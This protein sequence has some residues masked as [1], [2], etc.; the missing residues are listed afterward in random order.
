MIEFAASFLFGVLASFTP[1]MV[2]LYP[3]LFYRLSREK[4]VLKTIMLVSLGFLVVFSIFALFLSQI[5]FEKIRFGF[6]LVLVALGIAGLLKIIPHLSTKLNT[7]NPFLFG[8]TMA[9]VFST[10]PCSLPFLTTIISGSVAINAN[11]LINILVFSLGLLT[12]IILFSFL[13]NMAISHILMKY[14]NKL[15]ALEK[16]LN[17][18]IA[19]TGAYLV[20][21]IHELSTY[22]LWISSA[23]I[24]I[25]I[26][27]I[28][29]F[30]FPD[31]KKEKFVI[32]L[33]LSLILI[34]GAFIYHCQG[35]VEPSGEANAV[36]SY[37][38][39]CDYC[40]KCSYLFLSATI[41]GITAIYLRYYRK[42]SFLKKIKIKVK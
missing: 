24:F 2:A 32:F 29:Y 16:F 5:N 23:L 26:A 6:G 12:P 37:N 18:L 33:L 8:M 42:C 22:S 39:S 28:S 11:I 17:L 35:F 27:G 3:L 38:P 20:F 19:V 9:V 21:S 34:L 13:G 4:N 40:M 7:I 25:V 1:C 31:L 41:A 15:E 10:N 14:T 36:C 30:L